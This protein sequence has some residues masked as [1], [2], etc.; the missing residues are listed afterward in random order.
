VPQ[1]IVIVEVFIAQRDADHPLHAVPA[2]AGAGVE[3]ALERPGSRRLFLLTVAVVALVSC[4]I[5]P[6][7]LGI[8]GPG[9]APA[10]V[11]ETGGSEIPAPGVPDTSGAG[12][13]YNIGPSSRYFDYN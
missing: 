13:R 5:S 2:I 11:N 1:F 3:R 7:S 10:P 6:G 9:L 12:Y 4:D 8:T